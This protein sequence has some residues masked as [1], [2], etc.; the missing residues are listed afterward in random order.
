MFKITTAQ[1]SEFRMLGRCSKSQLLEELRA[2]GQTGFMRAL[3]L[4]AVSCVLEKI[5][6]L[7]QKLGEEQMVHSVLLLDEFNT[8]A[9]DA[10]AGGRSELPQQVIQT[11]ATWMRGDFSPNLH[12]LCR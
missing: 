2:I 1:G 5:Q 6:R 12:A 9:L 4:E 8:L 10:A 11:V 3:R 7:E